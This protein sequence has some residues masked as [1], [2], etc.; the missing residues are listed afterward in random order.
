[1]NIGSFEKQFEQLERLTFLIGCVFNPSH[2]RSRPV[3]TKNF[4]LLFLRDLA[5]RVE[6]S[7]II[8]SMARRFLYSCR[9]SVTGC[10]KTS[11]VVLGEWHNVSSPEQ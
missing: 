2:L 8:E 5:L 1:M 4:G 3:I 10:P 7:N 11:P 6:C 9:G